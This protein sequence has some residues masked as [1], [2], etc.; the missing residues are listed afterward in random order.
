[1]KSLI[2]NAGRI[3]LTLA[4]VA[5]AA[6]V[7][8]ELWDYYTN[9]PWTRDARV[10]ADVVQ[11]APDVAGLVAEVLV[12]DN[13]TVRKGAVLFR[14]DR[15]RF[16]IAVQQAEAALAGRRAALDVAEQELVR[17]R[18]PGDL[19]SQQRVEQAEAAKR[20]AVA[21][22]AQTQA[23]LELAKLNLERSDVRAS[24]NGIVSNLS[25]RPG[26]YVPAGKAV[27][28]LIDSDSIRVEGYFEETKLPRIHAGDAA[29]VTLM[30]R[31]GVLHGS[32]H[33]IAAGI[34]DRE[35]S[36]TFGR[37]ANV[38]PAFTWIR[39]AQRIP[40]RIKLDAPPD[41]VKLIVG[42]TATVKI[43]EAR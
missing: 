13:G 35:R 34:E 25:L 28:A 43:G 24:V 1:M 40:V 12:E 7:G 23:D 33:S 18:N 29:V 15:R 8:R 14:V 32:V 30:G 38:N 2:A 26:T 22:A 19:A 20:T 36:D 16:E 21:A 41:E 42:M 17:S 27:M 9:T 6:F 4:V 39:L 3:V 10:R 5:A 37:L 31:S 11:V